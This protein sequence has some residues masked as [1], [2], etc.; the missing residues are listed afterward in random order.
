MPVAYHSVP[1]FFWRNTFITARSLASVWKC[2]PIK[3]SSN[4]EMPKNWKQQVPDNMPDVEKSIPLEAC[5]ESGNEFGSM[6]SCIIVDQCDFF[7]QQAGS[8][9]LDHVLEA[10]NGIEISLLIHGILLS[11]LWINSLSNTERLSPALYPC[12]EL[13]CTFMVV[14]LFPYFGWWF[15]LRCPEVH[16]SFIVCYNLLEELV[17]INVVMTLKFESGARSCSVM[18][19]VEMANIGL[20]IIDNYR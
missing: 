7:W 15:G 6:W 10:K 17:S 2:L 19:V 14:L 4:L 20:F 13:L 11:I 18:F 8:L 9:W 16:P 1:I 3:I 5:D 12:M